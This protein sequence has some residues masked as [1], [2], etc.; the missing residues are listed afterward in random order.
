MDTKARADL[1]RAIRDES[2]QERARQARGFAVLDVAGRAQG[3][4]QRWSERNRQRSRAQNQR[5]RE[6]YGRIGDRIDA[7]PLNPLSP[8][9]RARETA[10][11]RGVNMREAQ[12]MR[13][14]GPDITPE[15]QRRSRAI[16][17]EARSAEMRARATGVGASNRWR[18]STRQVGL[19]SGTRLT[20]AQR[21]AAILRDRAAR[22][23]SAPN[24][25]NPEDYAPRPRTQRRRGRVVYHDRRGDTTSPRG[26]RDKR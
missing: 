7:H 4:V 5:S 3:R 22:T 15:F 1:V 13:E 14:H 21:T 25:T 24:S 12:R 20:E 18:G 16:G 17:A 10:R 6:I 8:A 19:E 23:R 2:K 9:A 11:L 26:G